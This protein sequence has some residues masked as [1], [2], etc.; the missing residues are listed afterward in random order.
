MSEKSGIQPKPRRNACIH[1]A[2]I[3][4]V[5]F[6]G[7][8]QFTICNSKDRHWMFLWL[9]HATQRHSPHRQNGLCDCVHGP[10]EK[11]ELSFDFLFCCLFAHCSRLW[12]LNIVQQSPY[13]RCARVI[14]VRVMDF[15]QWDLFGSRKRLISVHLNCVESNIV[16]P[17]LQSHF[18]NAGQS[19]YSA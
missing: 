16:G 8:A 2:N 18:D 19:M 10:L 4:D 3:D 12:I 1:I 15:M 11:F 17:C 14:G 13:V 7:T 9:F 5:A 6:N